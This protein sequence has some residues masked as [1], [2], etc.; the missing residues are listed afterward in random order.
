MLHF[1]VAEQGLDAA[2]LRGRDL[3]IHYRQGGERLKPALNRP[4]KGLKCH[5]QALDIPAWER[6]RLPLLYCGDDLVWA[7]GLGIDVRYR[8]AAKTAGWIPEW[9]RRRL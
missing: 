7:P 8:V 5:Y 4:T 6:E 3:R 1:D 2:W 9:R